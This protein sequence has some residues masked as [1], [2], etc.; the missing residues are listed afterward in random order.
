MAQKVDEVLGLPSDFSSDDRKLYQLELLADYE[1]RLRVGQAFD[2]LD[3]VREAVKHLAAYIEE[4]KENA[5]SVADNTKSQD[6]TKF[7]VSY[8]QRVARR[9]NYIYDRLLALRGETLT[10]DP[11]D[12]AS[13]LRRIDLT[14]DLKIANLKVARE[15]GDRHRSGSWIWWNGKQPAQDVDRAQWFR[16]WQEKLRYDEAVNILCAEF[17]A[18]IRGSAELARLWQAAA[19]RST[20]PGERAYALQHHAMFTRMSNACQGAYDEAR[21]DGVDPDTVDQSKVSAP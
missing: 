4:K 21:A 11:S 6:V 15:Q 18:T 17:R 10:I 3:R 5:H 7:S 16:A 8:C 9:Y 2:Q 14:K 13:R 20:V 1:V 19:E 12:P